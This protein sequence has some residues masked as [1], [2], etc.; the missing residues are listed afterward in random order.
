VHIVVVRPV[1][2]PNS[3][4]TVVLLV[5]GQAY[6]ESGVMSLEYRRERPNLENEIA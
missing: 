6:Y 1:S 3:R 2:V 5:K 4:D